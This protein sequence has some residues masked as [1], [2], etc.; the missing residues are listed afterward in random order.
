MQLRR[1]PR[2]LLLAAAVSTFACGDSDG[3]SGTSPSTRIVS[4][5]PDS[6]VLR[7]GETLKLTARDVGG[8]AVDPAT[9][10]WSSSNPGQVP[11]CV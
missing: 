9:V 1:S 10:T 11:S 6:V 3:S 8:A 2:R 7:P 4:V 5:T